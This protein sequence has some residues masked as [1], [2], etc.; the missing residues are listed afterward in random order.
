MLRA[1]ARTG[2]DPP[3]E[4]LAEQVTDRV[5]AQSMRSSSHRRLAACP[6][7]SGTCCS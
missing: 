5:A 3:A 4:S 1:I 2:G 6:A 7:I